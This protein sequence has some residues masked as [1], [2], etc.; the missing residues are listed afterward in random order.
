LVDTVEVGSVD[1]WRW[2][3][4]NSNF[5]TLV[6]SWG[7]ARLAERAIKCANQR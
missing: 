2:A 6:D 4:P 1:D 3:G 5:V 7:M